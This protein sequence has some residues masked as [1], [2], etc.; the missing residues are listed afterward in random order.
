MKKII[1]IILASILA[2]SSVVA[3]GATS[4]EISDELL[5]A[6]NA[7]SHVSISKEDVTI[8]D[9]CELSSNKSLVRYTVSLFGYSCDVVEQRIGQYKLHVSQRPLPK[10]LVEE[11]LYDIRDSYYSGVINDA[12]LEMIAEYKSSNFTF[13][14]I[15]ILYGD[16]NRD[17]RVSVSDATLIQMYQAKSTEN[18][19]LE[20][21]D[22]DHDGETTIFDATAIQMKLAKIEAE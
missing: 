16:V 14:K 8:Y 1:S 20:V 6:I 4:T 18:I 17:A 10:I 5:N 21:A 9:N 13:K 19:D 22:Y 15:G 11:K 2:I 12:E 3:V 7:N